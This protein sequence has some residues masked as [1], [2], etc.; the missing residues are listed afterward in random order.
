M[1]NTFPRRVQPYS[2]AHQLAKGEAAEA[3][4]DRHFATR[5]HIAP[6]TRAQQ[7]QGIDRHFTHRQSGA[8]YTIEYKTDWK[9]AHTGNAFV[10]TVS[11]DREKIPGWAY[12]SQAEWLAYFLPSHSTIYL[13]HF[14]E[15]RR[16]LPQWLATCKSAPPIPNR[17]YHTLGI[18]VPLK[19][20]AQI[21]AR[22]EEA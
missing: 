16:R 21:A 7:R 13:I 19:E 14:S 18:L 9:A 3:H 15:L 12:T 11:I 2:M 17:G 20:F 5:F 1:S 8:T 6:A 10:E 4:L 22:I